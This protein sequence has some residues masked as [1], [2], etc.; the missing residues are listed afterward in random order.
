MNARYSIAFAVAAALVATACGKAEAPTGPVAASSVE[1]AT[2]RD[3][4]APPVTKPPELPLPPLPSDITATP[5]A[6]PASGTAKDTAASQPKDAL[7]PEEEANAMPKAGHGNNHSS[8]S[9]DSA[10]AKPQ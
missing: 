10:P 1:A 3:P 2:S 8:P 6:G 5:G 4:M 7:T 9:L